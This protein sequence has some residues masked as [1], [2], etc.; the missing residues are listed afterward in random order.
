MSELTVEY[1]SLDEIRPYK[2]NAKLHPEAQIQEIIASIKEVGF[3]DPIGVWHDEIVEG[4]GR[5]EAAKRLGL[6]TVPII[7]L[8]DLTDEQ[9]RAYMIIHNKTTMDS[10]FNMAMLAKEIAEIHDIDM[11]LYGLSAS[12]IFQ[13]VDIR[14]IKEDTVPI[15]PTKPKAQFG[16]C[17]QLG[18]HFLMCGDSTNSEDVRRLM[19]GAKADLLFTDPPYNVAVKNSKGMTIKNDDLPDEQFSRF[20]SAAFRNA[21]ENVR[22]G[23]SFYIWYASCESY[24]FYKCVRDT[25]LIPKQEL[26]WVKNAFTLG[27]QDYKWKHEPCIYGWK[28]GAAHYFIKEYDNPTVI[29]DKLDFRK[30]TKDEMRKLLEEIYS[31]K[32]KT[33]VIYEDK[34]LANSLHPTMKPVRMCADLIHN[35]TKPGQIVLDLFG[36]SGSTMIACEQIKRKCYTMEY[37]PKYCD[38]II[39]RW[40][41]LTGSKAKQISSIA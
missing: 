35:S 12:D 17:W 28:A 2:Q 1:V 41:N 24:N 20:L 36:G 9:R 11:G 22:S 3:K 30:M 27:R 5:Y 19:S 31:D 33:S 23:G 7:R 39:Q 25:E 4:H 18:D 14:D 6:E 16:D 37:D 26:I 15:V 34:P 13:D 40:E 29:E 21:S 38:V 8:D 32:V 10:G